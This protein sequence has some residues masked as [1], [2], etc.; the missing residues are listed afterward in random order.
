MRFLS[1]PAYTLVELLIAL[2]L[3]LLLLLGVAELFQRVGGSLNEARSVI[4]VS[5]QLNETAMLLRKDLKQISPNLATKPKDIA[6]YLDGK[7]PEP[8][9]DKDDYGGYLEIIEGPNHILDSPTCFDCELHDPRCIDPKHTGVLNPPCPCSCHPYRNEYGKCDPT[10]GD[11][12]DIIAFTIKNPNVPFRGMLHG[13][14]KDRDSAE[15]TWFVRGNTLYR[16][17]RLIDDVTREENDHKDNEVFYNESTKE[18][19]PTKAA[20][21]EHG[22][23]TE[24]GY[25][26]VLE[27]ETSDGKKQRYD[28][29]QYGE[30]DWRWRTLLSLEDLALRARRFGHGGI[31]DDNLKRSTNTFPYALYDGE[32]AGWYYLRMPTF[33][34]YDFWRRINIMFWKTDSSPL[35]SPITN[36][37]L[38]DQPHFFPNSQDRK[39]GSLILEFT[40]DDGSVEKSI[41]SPRNHQAGEDVVLT[42][43]LSFDVKVWCPN[44]KEFVDL[45]AA[46][47][48]WEGEGNQPDLNHPAGLRTWDSWSKEYKDE[49][50]PYTEPL[51]A[52]QITIRCFEPASR[53]IKQVTVVH[54]FQ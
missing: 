7:R 43:V 10:V 47:T 6:D 11:V 4:K 48:T 36:P 22:P 18:P 26:W 37:D 44:T 40:K 3:S 31:G 41:T 51:E 33:E 49:L 19:F 30:D 25:A 20:L 45:G 2:A 8:P 27:D 12:D 23:P 5:A 15:V 34:E 52:I 35:G 21:D 53:I 42:N 54:R 24:A 1:S 9:D 14:I 28:A 38:W 13:T 50:P 16:R 29:V 46:G 39:S 17:I 32:H